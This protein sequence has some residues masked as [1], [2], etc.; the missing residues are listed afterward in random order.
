MEA[1]M[2]P[3]GTIENPHI[4]RGLPY[5]LNESALMT[6]RTWRCKPASKEGKAT[7]SRVAFEINFRL[8]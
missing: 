5:G 2:M 6:I 1:E 4:V 7:A 3:G 8:Y